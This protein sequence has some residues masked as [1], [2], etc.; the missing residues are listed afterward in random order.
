MTVE[1]KHS[2]HHVLKENRENIVSFFQNTIRDVKMSDTSTETIRGHIL[3]RTPDCETTSDIPDKVITCENFN[4]KKGVTIAVRFKEDN[5]ANGPTLNVNES[6][7]YPIKKN[8]E[9]INSDFIV[10][11]H[12]YMFNFN[13]VDW[14]L[15]GSD[16]AMK[17]IKY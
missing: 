16:G 1:Y 17:V 13:G 10:A 2:R 12:V 14:D 3:Y 6:G 15:I 9:V 8:G 7:A 5:I 4:L 11:G